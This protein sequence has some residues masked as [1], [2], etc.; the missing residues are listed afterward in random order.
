MTKLHALIIDD[1]ARNT[2]I[3]ARLLSDQDIHSTE[4]TNPRQIDAVLEHISNVDL[5]FLDLEMPG[6]DG[7]E[8][9]HKLKSNPKVRHAPIVACTVHVSEINVAYQRGFHSFIGKPV[10]PD[11]FPDQLLRILNGEQVWETT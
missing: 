9:L 11:R 8:V 3:L 4:L 6:L 2:S 5:I 1:N 10:D 7:Y